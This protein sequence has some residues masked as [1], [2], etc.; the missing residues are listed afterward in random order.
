MFAV[1]VVQVQEEVL[2]FDGSLNQGIDTGVLTVEINQKDREKK[3]GIL[4][5]S[6]RGPI[7]KKFVGGKRISHF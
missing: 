2:I 3:R 4:A 1:I 6:V 7:S 5:G